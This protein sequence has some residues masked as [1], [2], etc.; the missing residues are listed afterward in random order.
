MTK[1]RI[2]E[3]LVVVLA[4]LLI[5]LVIVVFDKKIDKL[6]GVTVLPI[7]DSLNNKINTK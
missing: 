7:K 2:P 1:K 4:I 5:V 6:N 3:V